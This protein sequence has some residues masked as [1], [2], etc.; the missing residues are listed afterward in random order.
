MKHALRS[1]GILLLFACMSCTSPRSD[2]HLHTAWTCFGLKDSFSGRLTEEQEAHVPESLRGAFHIETVQD[3]TPAA[4][5][6]LTA[7][8]ERVAEEM[9]GGVRYVALRDYR[10]VHFDGGV[11]GQ[12]IVIERYRVKE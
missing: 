11:S 8:K 10:C 3:I 4:L 6:K 7:R 9:R 12:M 5:K 2:G 1:F